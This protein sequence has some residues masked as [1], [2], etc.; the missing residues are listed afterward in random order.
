MKLPPLGPTAPVTVVR[1][2]VPPLGG[3]QDETDV[4]RS[5][6]QDEIAAPRSGRQ[7]V[8]VRMK[9]TSPC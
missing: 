2:K 4:P 3:G 9:L 6:G 8:K 1:M 5:S 7:V